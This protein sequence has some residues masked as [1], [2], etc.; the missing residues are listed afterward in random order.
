M[1]GGKTLM[2]VAR[3]RSLKI[4]TVLGARPQFIK[5]SAVSRIIRDKYR[6]KIQEI[7]IH[8]GQHYDDNM[9]KVFFQELE[10]PRPRYFLGVGGGSHGAMTGKM[11]ERIERVLLREKPD[12]VMVYGDTNSTL[13]GALAAAKLGISIAHV[14]AG[15]RSYDG[16]MPE[17]INRVLTDRLAKLLFCPDRR[18]VHNL[19]REGIRKGVHLVGDVMRDVFQIFH[20]KAAQASR[21]HGDYLLCTLHRQENTGS[22]QQT[23]GIFRALQKT[24]RRMRVIFPVHPRTRKILR[25]LGKKAVP[26]KFRSRDPG[27]QLLPPQPYAKFQSLL[28]GARGVITDSGGLQKE[29]YWGGK[30]CLV[31]RNNTEWTDYL[32]G[33]ANR[34]VSPRS[35]NLSIF[36]Q[37]LSRARLSR[38]ISESSSVAERIVRCLLT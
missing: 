14:E 20:K 6:G 33:G 1:S 8:T 3:R 34:V 11:I 22:P 10:I 21:P 16:R 31:L 7:L 2:T 17:E 5:A 15:L 32:R 18:S 29:A 24:A 28:L 12:W 13:A 9:S 30:P 19:A 23:L 35:R 27:L 38:P 37:N 36:M 25:G 4:V 26:K